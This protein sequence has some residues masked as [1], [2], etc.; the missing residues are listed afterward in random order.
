MPFTPSHILAVLPLRRL[1]GDVPFS[2][3]AIGAMVPDLPLFLPGLDYQ[4]AHSF[5]GLL[6]M[7]LPLGL[8]TCFCFEIVMRRPMMSLLP[9]WVQMRLSNQPLVERDLSLSRMALLA[10]CIL[11]AAGSH[12]LWDSFTHPARWGV[13]TF[14]VLSW[15]LSLYELELPLFRVLQHTSSVIGL[16]IVLCWA[17]YRLWISSVQPKNVI[18]N[19]K[20]IRYLVWAT[21][22]AIPIPV[23]RKFFPWGFGIEH[24]LRLLITHS[25]FWQLTFLLAYSIVF[26]WMTRSRSVA[27]I[28]S[29]ACNE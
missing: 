8:A 12:V 29:Q 4:L 10:C 25:G 18:E 7:C 23:F 11:V 19:S 9:E 6:T 2:A 21:L 24:F 3:L 5:P 20:L 26:Q 27:P 17:G 13:Q 16:L 15:K 1:F 14:S 28:Q 22:A